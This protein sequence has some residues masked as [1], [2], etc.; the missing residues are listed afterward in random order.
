MK[1]CLRSV[2]K[3]ESN[4]YEYLRVSVGEAERLVETKTY[5]YISKEEYKRKSKF[6]KL[7][8]CKG[9]LINVIDNEGNKSQKL[10]ENINYQKMIDSQNKV[11]NSSKVGRGS[12]NLASIYRKNKFSGNF[13]GKNHKKRK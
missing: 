7:E 13:Y 5:I 11:P 6:Y 9:Q 1:K 2:E 8:P 4:K 12:I 10:V 3:R